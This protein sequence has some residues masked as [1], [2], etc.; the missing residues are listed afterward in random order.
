MTIDPVE[1][2]NLVKYRIERST[3]T[4]KEAR[5]SIENEQYFNAINRIY[6]ANF[7]IVSALAL[8]HG[9]NTSKHAQLFGWFNKSFVKTNLVDEKFGKIL[10]NSFIRRTKGDY[11]DFVEFKEEEV[12]KLFQ[13]MKEFVSEIEKLISK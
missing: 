10:S 12:E 5:V 13:E 8:K 11:G 3:T 9:F 2:K 6:Y 4:V 1:R 7:Y